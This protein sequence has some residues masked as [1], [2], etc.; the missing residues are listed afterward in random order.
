LLLTVVNVDVDV[1]HACM[2][3]EQLQNAEHDVVDVAETWGE[4]ENTEI[5]SEWQYHNR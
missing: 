3:L 2:I 4:K 5:E 1:K